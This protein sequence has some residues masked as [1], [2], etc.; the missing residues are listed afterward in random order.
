MKIREALYVLD[1]RTSVN[2]KIHAINWNESV[3]LSHSPF[4]TQISVNGLR[5]SVKSRVKITSL[6]SKV[7]CTL[8]ENCLE[9][10]STVSSA[11]TRQIY[12]LCLLWYH[13]NILI[14]IFVLEIQK[15]LLSVYSLSLSS[16]KRRYDFAFWG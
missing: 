12:L 16:R 13:L 2:L 1:T 3:M 10:Y 15:F 7:F 14:I 5:E 9:F 8:T 11:L 4:D 6:C